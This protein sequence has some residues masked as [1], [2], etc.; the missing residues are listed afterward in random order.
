MHA[1]QF[2]RPGIDLGGA[3]TGSYSPTLVL[4]SIAISVVAAYVGLQHV[5]LIGAAGSRGLGRLWHALAAFALGAGV[6]AMHFVG[7]LAF[8]LPVPIAY[9]LDLTVL[10]LLPAVAAA[11]VALAFLRR[12]HMEM[13]PALAGGVV[14]G[15]GIAAMHYLGMS[16]MIVP[17]HMYYEPGL[18]FASVA[19]A[20]VMGT[21]AISARA[22]LH[23]VIASPRLVTLFSALALG[24]ATSAMHYAAMAAA[25]YLPLDGHRPAAAGLDR[26]VLAGGTAVAT[27]LILLVSLL[28][29]QLRRRVADAAALARAAT[30]EAS[31]LD[32]RLRTIAERVP[33]VVYQFRRHP[34][35]RYTMPYASEAIRAVL[36]VR[37]E[38]V[39]EDAAPVFA[40]I[41][42]D[43]RERLIQSIEESART[44]APW[45]SRF[46]IFTPE[47]HERWLMGNSLPKAD[48]D[49]T[50]DWDGFV[51]DVTDQ[52]RAEETV[53][54]LAFHDSLTD[55]PN[56]RQFY[57]RLEASAERMAERRQFGA[58]FFVDLDRFKLLN[59]L[60]G[61][62][63]GDE[64]LQV[65]ARRLAA[66][67]GPHDMLARLGGDEFVVAIENLGQ[68][69]AE[70]AA[71]AEQFGRG[72]LEKVRMRTRGSPESGPSNSA[73]IGIC[74]F[75][76]PERLDADEIVRRADFAMYN[77]KRAGG[78]TV[79]RFDAAMREVMETRRILERDLH[80]A[81]TRSQFVLH[82]QR[83]VD[84]DGCVVGAEALIR[85]LHPRDGLIS[86]D[87]FIGLAEETGLIVP[88]GNWVLDQ[89]CER[90]REW[91]SRAETAD[92]TLSVNVSAR[93][94]Y[95]DD[96]VAAVADRLARAGVDPRCL[97]IEI[98]ESLLLRDVGEARQIVQALRELG[99]RC[100]IDD[101]G[102]GYS[103]LSYLA[104]LEVAELKID[105]SFTTRIDGPAAEKERL[106]VEAI[107]ELGRRL[108]IQVCA[109]GVETDEQFR[110]LR[111]IN[112]HV[113]QGY[114][115]GHPVRFEE[116][117]EQPRLATQLC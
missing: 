33:G 79:R 45:Q 89:V 28:S 23:R 58:L 2:L 90:L 34:D 103:S 59:D 18:F 22:L 35:G 16:G 113:F 27:G 95:Q 25:V 66:A 117:L 81:I 5:H 84:R 65:I 51:M 50:V 1:I 106:V 62:D 32:E 99:V 6:W 87:R 21:V 93:Q 19:I 110:L 98:T 70:A 114:R 64:L 116:M 24:L 108:G 12:I 7:M 20:I 107:V 53:R 102:T 69:A 49:G 104:N 80:E 91:G 86:P 72:L 56:R 105:R 68:N 76:G 96:F 94:F 88:I 77:A 60:R 30:V 67:T 36:G 44:L 92:L 83:Q 29:T 85:W 41:H 40:S 52:R 112:C 15:L 48:A 100:A 63:A 38:Q 4:L 82:Y 42:P 73:S 13:W 61:H 97:K 31:R 75:G 74:L 54:R 37:P 101:F 11:A 3:L 8:A 109:E 111:A 9:R 71:R 115:F 26:S 17:A 46:R 39:A 47:G 14:M 78:N 55:L 57:E 43:D 10:S